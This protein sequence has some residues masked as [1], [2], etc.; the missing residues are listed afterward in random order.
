MCFNPTRMKIRMLAPLVLAR[1]PEGPGRGA[2]PGTVSNSEGATRAKGM[3]PGRK[4]REERWL[5]PY[6]THDGPACSAT[7]HEG[8]VFHT[9][10][11]AFRRKRGL[12]LDDHVD[13]DLRR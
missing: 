12:S 3:V 13:A 9:A 11:M 10:V 2:Q 8:R 1:I 4:A 5:R 7:A 6:E